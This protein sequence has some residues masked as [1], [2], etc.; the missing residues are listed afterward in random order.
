MQHFLLE[1]WAIHNFRSGYFSV[2]KSSRKHFLQL[3]PIN[4]YFQNN[5]SFFNIVLFIYPLMT[6]P[7]HATN[8][9]F[10]I[11]EINI[12][13]NTSPLF[14][15]ATRLLSEPH[16][17]LLRHFTSRPTAFFSVYKSVTFFFLFR[18]CPET[19][20]LS[21][22]TADAAVQVSSIYKTFTQ[23]RFLVNGGDV[24][25]AQHP[26]LAGPGN[27]KSP[28]S[29]PSPTHQPRIGVQIVELFKV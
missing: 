20:L 3:F 22:Y 19:T 1:N 12:L 16:K 28:S 24:A 23:I 26:G 8:V 5:V 11:I 29:V 10:S 21:A 4:A 7:G 6:C 14:F 18:N 17:T 15:L 2:L 25:R 13:D 27:R 9:F